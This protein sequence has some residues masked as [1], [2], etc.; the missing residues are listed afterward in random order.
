MKPLLSFLL[1]LFGLSS[2]YAQPEQSVDSKIEHVTVY[3]KGAQVTRSAQVQLPAGES[4]LLFEGLPHQ[5]WE[6]SLSLRASGTLT[7]LSLSQ[8]TD[9]LTE[10]KTGRKAEQLQQQQL[11]IRD[12][13]ARLENRAQ[14]YRHERE[15]MLAN[16]SIGGQQGVS[17]AE[18]EQMADLFRNRLIDIEAQLQTVGNQSKLLKK[19]LLRLSQALLELNVQADTPPSVTVRVRVSSDKAQRSRLELQYVVPEAGWDPFYNLRIADTQSPMVL[20]Y[21][22]KVF[23]NTGEAWD[24]VSLSLSTGN[25]STNNVKPELNTYY[26]TFNNYYRP[27]NTPAPPTAA[28]SQRIEGV[29]MD[30]GEPLIGASVFVDGTSIGTVTGLDG[31]YSLEVPPGSREL[32][33]SYVGYADQRVYIQGGF[34][35]I[36]L[37]QSEM[38]LDEVVVTGRRSARPG[39]LKSEKRE[40]QETVPLAVNKQFT[41]TNFDIEVPYSIPSDDKPYDVHMISHEVPAD[42]HYAVVPKLS[43]QAYL[44]AA[45]TDWSQYS[46]LSGEAN[47]FLKG[48]YQG[49]SYLDMEA[50]ED[51]LSVSV[52]RDE[53]IVVKREQ[54]KDK[55]ST[56]FLGGNKTVE[57][58]WRTT[59]RNTNDYPVNLVAEDQYPISKDDD[60]KVIQLGHDGGK[61]DEETGKVT[62]SFT[63]PAGQTA[64]RVLKYAVRYPKKRRLLVE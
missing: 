5:L 62:W 64:E 29:V 30:S 54:V 19:R 43:D 26:L 36:Q 37:E 51:T 14:V 39:L 56:S 49:K 57:R 18:L 13:I 38:M 50:F 28:G 44:V 42:Y 7:V 20:E 41:S 45:V 23:Q 31:R 53:D 16:R 17:A 24:A 60:I 10:N 40:E 1:L 63:L 8:A 11:A 22:A 59:I 6:N 46:L 55:S 48:T 47:L 32:T 2:L 33:I 58:S 34:Q 61:L 3:R 27:L 21:K 12:S 4:V 25:P 35:T 9:Y 52:G 15:M